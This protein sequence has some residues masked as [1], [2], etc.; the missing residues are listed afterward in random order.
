MNYIWMGGRDGQRKDFLEKVGFILCSERQNSVDTLYSKMS[1]IDFLNN[2]IPHN[3]V[4]LDQDL[5]KH[6]PNQQ[7]RLA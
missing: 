5:G 1:N 4:I 2:Y 6:F 7:E 3:K